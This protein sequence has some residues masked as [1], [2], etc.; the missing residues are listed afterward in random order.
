MNLQNQGK[1]VGVV[2]PTA[3][4]PIF[5]I[6]ALESILDGTILPHRIVMIIDSTGH[7]GESELS[8]M[9]Q[10]LEKY[11][12]SPVVTV[13]KG[14]GHGPAHARN[15]GVE[16]LKTEY[17]AFLDSDDLWAPTKLERQLQY[18]DKRPHLSGCQTLER[19]E[20]NGKQLN[21]PERLIPSAGTMT[22]ESMEACMVSP[23]SVILKRDVFLSIGGFDPAF[24]VCEDY[25]LWLRLLHKYSM[26]LVPEKLVTKRSGGWSQLSQRHSQDIYRARA[27]LKNAHLWTDELRD[28]AGEIFYRKLNMVKQ[29]AE[30]RGLPDPGAD[31][32]EMGRK[33]FRQRV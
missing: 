17:I 21:Q 31:L 15:M 27:L 23:S 2:I 4:R 26:G 24:P 5:M 22:V 33:V 6:E 20:K 30:K 32:R 10:W 12:G 11:S 29:G 16:E 18:L 28:R 13:L 1:K 14:G 9:D 19:W 25:E 7:D 3:Q 8:V